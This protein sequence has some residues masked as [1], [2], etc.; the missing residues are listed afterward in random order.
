MID[1]GILTKGENMSILYNR[2]NSLVKKLNRYR[3]DQDSSTLTHLILKKK[4][5]S[6]EKYYFSRKHHILIR[7]KEAQVP[8]VPN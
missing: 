8:A 7:D 1:I 5:N 3:N 2:L 6:E 4:T